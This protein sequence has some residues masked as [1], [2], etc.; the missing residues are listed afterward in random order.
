MLRRDQA[1]EEA[2]GLPAW[3]G[4]RMAW[5][6]VPAYITFTWRASSRMP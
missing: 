1:R 3:I 6:G 4:R 2:P 5:S